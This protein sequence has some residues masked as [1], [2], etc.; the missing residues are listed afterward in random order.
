MTVIAGMFI[1]AGAGL[2]DYAQADLLAV[3]WG[4][5]YV[6][7][8]QRRQ[9]DTTD[10][11]TTP[12]GSGDEYGDPHGVEPY[13]P[14]EINSIDPPE[15]Y[16]R[17][18]YVSEY[19]NDTDPGR[20]FNPPNDYDLN[21]PSAI[22]YGG[23]VAA[24]SKDSENNSGF[25]NLSV[26]NQGNGGNGGGDA[27]EIE[28]K[29]PGNDSLGEI[30]DYAAVFFW[31]K[32]DFLNGLDSGNL[33][34]GDTTLNL[35]VTQNA[36]ANPIKDPIRWVVR[37]SGD[38]YISTVATSVGPNTD[39]SYASGDL[40]LLTWYKYDPRGALKNIFSE[41]GVLSE[42][43]EFS[44]LND[45][46]ALGF[47]TE[48]GRGPEGERDSGGVDMKIKGFTATLGV[49]PEPSFAMVG[50][51]GVGLFAVR[52]LRSRRSQSSAISSDQSPTV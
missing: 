43:K 44:Q 27:I 1:G 10:P 23:A 13:D 35:K 16:L 5:N 9:L 40:A 4:G 14:P 15:E 24:W 36:G 41:I 6:G 28:V 33:I 37:N 45:V 20:P 38:F 21:K 48:W 25:T 11:P 8:G 50:L 31:D 51:F 39:L 47:Y 17:G 29:P 34:L 3:N 49:V 22:F 30:V 19:L 2:Q 18:R 52:R 7:P 32:K 42:E 26:T 12:P 46:T